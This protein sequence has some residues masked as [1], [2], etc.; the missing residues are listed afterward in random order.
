METVDSKGSDQTAEMC[1]LVCASDVG[2]C[3]KHSIWCH[4]SFPKHVKSED[5]N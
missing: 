3:H 5:D 1:R 2:I 4:G